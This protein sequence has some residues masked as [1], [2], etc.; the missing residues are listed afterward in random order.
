MK[1]PPRRATG[2]GESGLVAIERPPRQTN[3]KGG[4]GLVAG[5]RPPPEKQ[6]QRRTAH[7]I[8]IRRIRR[9]GCCQPE[10]NKQTKKTTTTQQ[11]KKQGSALSFLGQSH[12]TWRMIY[13]CNKL[14]EQK[15]RLSGVGSIIGIRNG[16]FSRDNSMHSS[17]FIE[18]HFKYMLDALL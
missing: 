9:L 17:F 2:I 6:G 3:G 11:H 8:R 13:S 10:T 18:V 16:T 12:G 7:S 1:Q 4:S 15:E 5:E 14:F